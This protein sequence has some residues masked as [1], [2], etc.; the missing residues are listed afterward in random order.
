[1]NARTESPAAE[2]VARNAGAEILVPGGYLRK[3]YTGR[4]CPEV[5][6]YIF[7]KIPILTEKVPLSHA[8]AVGRER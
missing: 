6:P 8:L 7:F 2:H 1:M 4:L 3:F 5:R